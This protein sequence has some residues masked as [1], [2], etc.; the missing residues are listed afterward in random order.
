MIVS[1]EALAA[2]WPA[3]YGR[4]LQSQRRGELGVIVNRSGW[5]N[6]HTALVAVVTGAGAA[7][8]YRGGTTA[9]STM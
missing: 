7:Y 9:R 6:R 3:E 2:L 4:A 8:W 1:E 5:I